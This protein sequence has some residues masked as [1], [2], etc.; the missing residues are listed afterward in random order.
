MDK[1][2]DREASQREQRVVERHLKECPACQKRL[3]FMGEIKVALRRPIME[4][5]ERETFPWVWEKIERE[6]RFKPGGTIWEA[7]KKGFAIT[8]FLKKKL[9]IPAGV[10]ATLLIFLV[11]FVLFKKTSFQPPL[12]VVEY[13]E[14][15]TNNVMIYELENSKVT[16]IWLFEE[17]EVE[18]S[19]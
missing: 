8:P 19:T 3:K 16:V 10:L 6:I 5:T 11:S 17:N 15:K 9:W 12:S 2:F 18:S 14:S 4:A 13:I 7:I 1:Y